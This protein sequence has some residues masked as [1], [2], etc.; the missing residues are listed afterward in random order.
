MIPCG[1]WWLH[2]YEEDGLF[3]IY[4]HLHLLLTCF[5]SAFPRFHRILCLVSLIEEAWL[6]RTKLGLGLSTAR[7]TQGRAGEGLSRLG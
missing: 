1:G 3:N 5:R 4:F 6:G 2:H 7:N